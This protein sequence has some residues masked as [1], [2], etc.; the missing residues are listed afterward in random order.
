MF[1]VIKAGGQQFCVAQN[2]VIKINKINA[3]KDTVIDIN[4]VLMCTDNNGKTLIGTP[5]VAGASVKV[6]VL[7]N[8]KNDKVIVFKK[9]RRHNYRRKN[10]HRQQMTVVKVLEILL[11][12]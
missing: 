8:I 2:D 7:D 6:Q 1:A 5:L 4:D 12:K 10:G 9:H 3:E 11:G